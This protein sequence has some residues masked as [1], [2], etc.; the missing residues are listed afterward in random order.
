MNV[1]A[2]MASLADKNGV[3]CTDVRFFFFWFSFF[4]LNKDTKNQISKLLFSSQAKTAY[5]KGR[6]EM[7]VHTVSPI[8]DI[9]DPLPGVLRPEKSLTSIASSQSEPPAPVL[10]PTVRL[11]SSCS[12]QI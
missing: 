5:V 11:S 10:Q 8:L 3:M 4:S 7:T 6:G 2:R 9:T 12:S 1:S